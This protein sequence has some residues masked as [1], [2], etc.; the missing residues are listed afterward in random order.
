MHTEGV[1]GLRGLAVIVLAAAV[2][3]AGQATVAQGRGDSVREPCRASELSA[4]ATFTG[5]GGSQLGGVLIRNRS[6][7]VCTIPASPVL[8]VR[9]QDAL[10]RPRQARQ[11]GNRVTL[12][13]GE[14]VWSRAQWSNWCHVYPV[15]DQFLPAD[16]EIY[17]PGARG[18]LVVPFV[19]PSGETIRVPACDS[20]GRPSSMSLGRFSRFFGPSPEPASTH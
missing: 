2:V 1:R 20:R 4:W 8:Y 16:A 6:S 5:S 14:R 12:A 15:E 17:L 7:T 19:G 11:L 10:L 13:A 3:G 18:H 9:V